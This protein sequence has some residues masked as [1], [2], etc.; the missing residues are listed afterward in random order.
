MAFEYPRLLRGMLPMGQKKAPPW[1]STARRFTFHAIFFSC[2]PGHKP[3]L[4]QKTP[5]GTFFVV[6]ISRLQSF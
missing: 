3:G 6:L 5:H 2:R 1:S 4:Q